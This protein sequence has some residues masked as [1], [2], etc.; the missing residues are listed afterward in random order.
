MSKKKSIYEK[1]VDAVKEEYSQ[2]TWEGS[3]Q[4]F[5]LSFEKDPY[6]VCRTSEQ[7]LYDAILS[8]GTGIVID[9]GEPILTYDIFLDPFNNH[10]HAIFGLER[11]QRYIVTDLKAFALEEGYTRNY[12]LI[13]PPGSCKTPHFNLVCKGVEEYS[14]KPEGWRY[15]FGFR[16]LKEELDPSFFLGQESTPQKMPGPPQRRPGIPI[17]Q[18]GSLK[19]KMLMEKVKDK[20]NLITV[21]GKKSLDDLIKISE[22]TEG[23]IVKGSYADLPS[24]LI[25]LELMCQHFENPLNLIPKRVV[26]SEGGIQD[27]RKEILEESFHKLNQER[28]KQR[29]EKKPIPR[30]ILEQELC[31]TCDKITE[32]LLKEYEGDYSKV[33]NHVIVKNYTL[34]ETKGQ[35]VSSIEPVENLETQVIPFLSEKVE[36]HLPNL[37]LKKLAGKIVGTKVLHHHDALKEKNFKSLSPTLRLVQDNRVGVGNEFSI[38]MDV[39]NLYTSNDTDLDKMKKNKATEAWFDRT[40]VRDVNFVL[41][42]QKEKL[43][44]VQALKNTQRRL[45]IAPHTIDVAAMWAVLTRLEKPH[46]YGYEHLKESPNEKDRALYATKR[47]IYEGLTPLQKLKIYYAG[48][49]SEF[50]EIIRLPEHSD[51]RERFETL[52]EGEKEILFSTNKDRFSSMIESGLSAMSKERRIGNMQHFNDEEKRII[53]PAFM[54]HLRNENPKEGKKGISPRK[55][56]DLFRIVSKKVEYNCL[57]PF[58]VFEFLDHIINRPDKYTFM[59]EESRTI[60]DND[61]QNFKGFINIVKEEYEKIIREEVIDS[62]SDVDEEAIDKVVRKY[63]EHVEAWVNDKKLKDHYSGKMVEP[64]EKLMKGVEGK[65]DVSDEYTKTHREDLMIKLGSFQREGKLTLIPIEGYKKPQIDYNEHFE[66][67]Y[68]VHRGGERILKISLTNLKESLIKM[69][70]DDFEDLPK[71]YKKVAKHV[72]E[73]MKKNYNYCSHCAK[74]T[75]LYAIDVGLLNI[76]EDDTTKNGRKGNEPYKFTKPMW[77]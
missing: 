50:D 57:N 43:I 20:K 48:T 26:D 73:N 9:S 42:M 25:D 19:Y 37:D 54:R 41:N 49:P 68:D 52:D 76:F 72:I 1:T 23:I 11:A 6:K 53:T 51:I 64:D 24:C 46:F 66:Q 17:A 22:D 33:L 35:G 56:Q 77:D 44:Y 10:E 31:Q 28:E 71:M 74:G 21:E 16:F 62:I 63:F 70:S 13:G 67:Y 45:H 61:Y 12:L 8:Y 75:V 29:L 27:H 36:R 3:W 34:S 59:D 2:S 18:E 15:S 58:H 38:E 4:D 14:K 30:K 47:R 65:L 32:Y 69:D 40:E 55:V 7:H 5:L 39:V 60:N